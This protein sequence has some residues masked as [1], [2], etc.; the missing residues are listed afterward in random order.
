MASHGAGRSKA[1]GRQIGRLAGQLVWITAA[2]AARQ[3]PRRH[4][5]RMGAECE[6]TE[7]AGLATGSRTARLELPVV[8][9]AMTV[10]HL[11]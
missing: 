11:T 5:R 1:L 7:Q 4:R 10:G 8:T 2:A 9:V 3:S 6:E